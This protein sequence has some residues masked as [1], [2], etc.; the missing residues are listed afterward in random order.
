MVWTRDLRHSAALLRI[1]CF[2]WVPGSSLPPSLPSFS[3]PL[4]LF[5]SLTGPYA[6]NL[7][8]ISPRA[9]QFALRISLIL[10]E[11]AFMRSDSVRALQSLWQWPPEVQGRRW[12]V[13]SVTLSPLPVIAVEW[14]D[15]TTGWA[16]RPSMVSDSAVCCF[17]DLAF[18]FCRLNIILC[19]TFLG[20]DSLQATVYS[21]QCIIV[22]VVYFCQG[23]VLSLFIRFVDH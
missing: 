6:Q 19:A 8:L 5:H 10:S 18:S 3:F 14:P 11:L 22:E 9:D 21:L 17:Q 7:R 12:K 1:V 2:A 16:P 23:I 20:H 13:L 15:R 4:S